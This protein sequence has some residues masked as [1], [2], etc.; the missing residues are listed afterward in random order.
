MRHRLLRRR[1]LLRCGSVVIKERICVSKTL[2]LVTTN[3]K[4]I[5]IIQ[6][7]VTVQKSPFEYPKYFFRYLFDGGFGG[8]SFG[9]H[10]VSV[11]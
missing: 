8:S 6:T 1:R 4:K 2:K 5:I 11:V 10:C 7:S 9:G 3:C